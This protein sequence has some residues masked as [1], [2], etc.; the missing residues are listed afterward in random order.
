[1]ENTHRPAAAIS[2]MMPAFASVSSSGCKRRAN[3]HNVY[4]AKI[5]EDVTLS[6]R[7]LIKLNNAYKGPV[8]QI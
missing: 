4:I 5:H 1:M 2:S 8:Y 3:R 6:L 7:H